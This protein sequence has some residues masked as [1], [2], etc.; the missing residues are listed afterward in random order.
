MEFTP[1]PMGIDYY[2][3]G[4]IMT[5]GSIQPGIVAGKVEVCP[6]CGS[7]FTHTIQISS[8]EKKKFIRPFCPNHPNIF[9]SKYRVMF[10]KICHHH[11]NYET[12]EMELMGFRHEHNA[13]SFDERDYKIK[14]KPLSFDRLADEWLELKS[15]QIRPSSLRSLA[16]GMRKAQEAWGESN[17]KSIKYSQV[18][19]FI[20]SYPGAPKSK[21]NALAALKQFWSWVHDRYDIPGIKKWPKLGYIEMAYRNTVDL[22]T[23]ESIIADIRKHEPFKV[24]LCIKWL[25][26]YIAVR[27]G[28]MQS[29]TE[30]QVDRGRGILIIPH[31][32][33]K[34]AKIIPLIEDDID[35]IRALPI[36]FDQSVPFFR[37][38]GG[39]GGTSPGQPFGGTRLYHAWRN[40]CRRLGV[41][42]VSLYPGTKH[43][44]AMGLR[45]ALTPEEIKSMTLHSTSAA[46]NRYFQTSGEALR[47]LQNTRKSLVAPDNGLTTETEQGDIRQVIN[48]TKSA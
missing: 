37:H 23:Q 47:K 11:S 32:K 1:N 48:F 3:Q 46:F 25:A 19:D 30:N 26:T 2:K 14:T 16:A 8:G 28:E 20:T 45:V 31:P 4:N 18:E 34:R 44:T 42:G 17:I 5:K 41:D 7:K 36:A 12:A 9:P 43:S 33:E 6:A 21:S 35:I 40:A 29:L 22:P 15:T 38:E 27:P 10:D 13:G 24:W 39:A